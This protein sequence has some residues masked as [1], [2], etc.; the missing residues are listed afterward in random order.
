MP[1]ALADEMAS[2]TTA[3]GSLPSPCLTTRTPARCPH[4]SSCSLAAARKVSAAAT[5]TDLPCSLNICANLP[6]AVVL[7][8]PFTPERSMTRGYSY[9]GT[10]NS[11]SPTRISLRSFLASSGALTFSSYTLSRSWSMTDSVAVMPISAARS[12]SSKFS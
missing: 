12:A 11:M 1:F 9:S 4:T 6:T 3:A 10:S 7:P 5:T 8:T 2:N